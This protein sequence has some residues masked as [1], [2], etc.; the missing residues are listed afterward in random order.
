MPIPPIPTACQS[1]RKAPR[2]PS[3]VA[4]AQCM[5]VAPQKPP[6]N[7]WLL[8]KTPQAFI[9]MSPP[10]EARSPEHSAYHKLAGVL[11]GLTEEEILVAAEFLNAM[12]SQHLQHGQQRPQA[13]QQRRRRVLP[14]APHLPTA[15]P[16][17]QT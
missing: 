16:H 2:L 1:L 9:A 6:M 8:W 11:L 17:Q 3:V 4:V 15:Q 14:A 12:L 5:V 7:A 10:W 13:R